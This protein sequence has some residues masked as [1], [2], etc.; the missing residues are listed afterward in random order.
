MVGLLGL[1]GLLGIHRCLNGT[2]LAATRVRTLERKVEVRRGDE[3][4]LQAT[5]KRTRPADTSGQCYTACHPQSR[6]SQLPCLVL[7]ETSLN[8]SR[9]NWNPQVKAQPTAVL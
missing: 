3:R 2:N 6:F 4:A 5:N 9:L 7:V 8:R 1:A